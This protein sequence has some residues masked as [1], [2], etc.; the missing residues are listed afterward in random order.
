MAA[1]GWPDNA[2][3]HLATAM[4]TGIVSTTATNP[5]DVVKTY[6]FVGKCRICPFVTTLAVMPEIACALS[7][8]VAMGAPMPTTTLHGTDKAHPTP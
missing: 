6:M 2:A 3:T 7:I 8:N 4:I 1:T 5:V